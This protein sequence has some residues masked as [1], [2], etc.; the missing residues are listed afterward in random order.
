MII[1]YR[2]EFAYTPG[3]RT[4]ESVNGKLNWSIKYFK[5]VVKPTGYEIPTCDGDWE[6]D[7]YEEEFKETFR[8]KISKEEYEENK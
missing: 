8:K 4:I 7:D 3:T 2:K 6:G 1:S 5:V